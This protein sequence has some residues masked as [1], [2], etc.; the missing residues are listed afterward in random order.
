MMVCYQG[1]R[2]DGVGQMW[3]NLTIVAGPWGS[4]LSAFWSVVV[5]LPGEN[6]VHPYFSS[7]SG[8]HSWLWIY[9]QADS[10]SLVVLVAEGGRCEKIS[11][12]VGRCRTLGLR[13]WVLIHLFGVDLYCCAF[14]STYNQGWTILW[15]H[16][17]YFWSVNWV[18]LCTTVWHSCSGV[19]WEL[20]S[21]TSPHWGGT[22]FKHFWLIGWFNLSSL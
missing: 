15:K 1:T 20:F 21:M 11:Q 18:S 12:T 14:F 2:G 10:G 16:V 5:C 17:V 3:K 6:W 19:V 22:I 8:C 9:S 4:G 13:F 7:L